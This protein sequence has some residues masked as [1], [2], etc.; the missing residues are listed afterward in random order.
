MSEKLPLNIFFFYNFFNHEPQPI[1][2]SN[3]KKQ[4][5]SFG[6]PRPLLLWNILYNL[7][8]DFSIF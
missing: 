3:I 4:N 7:L 6:E 8:R 5:V 2:L 1:W